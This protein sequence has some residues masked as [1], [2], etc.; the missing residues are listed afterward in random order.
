MNVDGRTGSYE[1]ADTYQDKS[2]GTIP[3]FAIHRD[4]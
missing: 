3:R 4:Q 1:Y 2:H